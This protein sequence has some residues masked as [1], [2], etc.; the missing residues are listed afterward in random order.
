M[1]GRRQSARVFQGVH[2][3]VQNGTPLL[4]AAVMAAAHDPAPMDQHAADWDAALCQA[5]FGLGDRGRHELVH[6][7]S[8]ADARSR[9][10]E[11]FVRT[12]Y[13]TSATPKLTNQA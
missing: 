13:V 5:G 7:K 6:G 1:D 2:F 8:H 3:A 12:T 11:S 4:H 10:E 9:E